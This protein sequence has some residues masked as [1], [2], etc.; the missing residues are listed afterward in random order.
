MKIMIEHNGLWAGR[1]ANDIGEQ[2]DVIIV[3]DTAFD[4][5]QKELKLPYLKDITPNEKTRKH[6]LK[7]EEGK[8]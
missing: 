5:L 4:L 7:L 1:V 2:I 8:Y 6:L 3:N